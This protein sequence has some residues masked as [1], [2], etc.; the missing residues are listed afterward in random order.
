MSVELSPIQAAALAAVA[1]FGAGFVIA[2]YLG[3]AVDE[4]KRDTK[5]EGKKEDKKDNSSDK[6]NE[7]NRDEERKKAE[8]KKVHNESVSFYS[9]PALALPSFSSFNSLIS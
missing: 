8:S 5:A 1:S 6:K 2:R 7:G 9:S 3:A 4:P